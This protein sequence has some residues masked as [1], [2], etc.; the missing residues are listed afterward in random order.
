MLSCSPS[1]AV[2]ISYFTSTAHV[3]D[4]VVVR[5]KRLNT[6]MDILPQ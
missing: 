6:A 4:E 3:M 5:L 2:N 1:I